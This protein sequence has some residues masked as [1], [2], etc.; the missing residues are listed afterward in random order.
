MNQTVLLRILWKEYRQLRALWLV[1]A[2]LVIFVQAVTLVV[3]LSTGGEI[4]ID[5]LFGIGLFLPLCYAL[6]CGATLF[7][8][9]HESH[10]YDFQ[11]ALPVSASRLAAGKIGLGLFSTLLMPPAMWLS[12]WLMSGGRLP[13]IPVPLEIGLAGMLVLIAL[14]AWSVLWSLLLG[15]VL[16]SVVLSA[17]SAFSATLLIIPWLGLAFRYLLPAYLNNLANSFALLLACGL[18]LLVTDYWLGRRWLREYPLIWNRPRRERRA[19]AFGDRQRSSSRL[20]GWHRLVW[21]AW[22]QSRVNLALNTGFPALA[23]LLFIVHAVFFLS[24]PVEAFRFALFFAPAVAAFVGSTIFWADQRNGQYAFLAERG[25]SPRRIWASRQ[26]IG[27]AAVAAYYAFALVCLAGDIA[28]HHSAFRIESVLANDLSPASNVYQDSGEAIVYQISRDAVL[29]VFSFVGLGVVLYSVGQACSLMIR[30]GPVAL[31]CGLVCGWA[32]GMWAG[33]MWYLEVPLWFSVAPIPVALLWAS[34][35]RAPDW[36]NERVRWRHRWKLLLSVVV[37]LAAVV[38]AVICFR[39][40]EIPLRQPSLSPEQVGPTVSREALETAWAYLGAD[41]DSKSL[42]DYEPPRD[43]ELA[44]ADFLEASRRKECVFPTVLLSESLSKDDSVADLLGVTRF[45]T[46][47][48]RTSGLVLDSCDALEAE[49]RLDEALDRY[50]AVLAFSRHFRN[51][52][53]WHRQWQADMIEVQVWRRL[54][55]WTTAAD[56]TAERIRGAIVRLDEE[57]FSVPV[58]RSDAILEGYRWYRR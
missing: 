18:V 9:E 44:I 5:E 7:A 49:G 46:V 31:F 10:T 45:A 37:P 23:S 39:V 41:A 55:T 52:G 8:G 3:G 14:F 24:G 12:A 29:Y 56:Q 54:D 57:H 38:G 36:M 19:A 11:R 33:L 26:M 35:L 27:I 25:V 16:W 51:C 42:A 21:H 58:P 30:S 4:P 17:V 47:V 20:P 53:D 1:I 15:R 22:R 2:A 32:A 48:T 50:F 6:G 43:V 34:W 13:R 28:N 40:Y